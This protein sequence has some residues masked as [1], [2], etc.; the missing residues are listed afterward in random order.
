MTG[1][2]S[3]E[4]HARRATNCGMCEGSNDPPDNLWNTMHWFEVVDTHP[5]PH[6]ESVIHGLAAEFSLELGI[7]AP[8]IGWYKAANGCIASRA[9]DA[10]S[11]AQLDADPTLSDCKYFRTFANAHS[12]YTPYRSHTIM[13]RID[14]PMKDVL[15]AVAD[16]CFHVFRTATRGF[17]WQ[18]FGQIA[19]FGPTAN[20]RF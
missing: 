15:D 3:T 8:P 14:A 11:K 18:E 2:V 4:N 5:D 10:S 13:I 19:F 9:Y 12:G 6:L 17:G 20:Q 16:E 1:E 7:P